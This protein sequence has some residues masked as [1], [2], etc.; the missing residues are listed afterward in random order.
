MPLHLHANKIWIID[1]NEIIGNIVCDYFRLNTPHTPH[2]FNSAI[3]AQKKLR[4]EKP[5]VI[6]LD[7]IMPKCSG[8]D[9]IE[10]LKK[11][12]RTAD[13]PIFMLTG[14]KSGQE[15]EIACKAAKFNGYFTKP[16]DLPLIRKRLDYFFS[17]RSE[18]KQNK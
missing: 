9:F 1:D 13:I 8:L 4:K 17:Q 15:F 14:L 10:I 11:N 16:V 5:D 18:N 12:K 6:L 7:W 3:K 2:Y